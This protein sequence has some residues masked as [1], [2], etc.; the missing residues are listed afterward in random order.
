MTFIRTTALL[1]VP[2]LTW[3]VSQTSPS[4]DEWVEHSLASIES[5]QVGMT[6]AELE[7]IFSKEGGLSTRNH[8]TYVYRDCRYFKVDVVFEAEPGTKSESP[9]DKI[10]SISRP[11]LSRPTLD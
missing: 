7:Q 8:R 1:L 5:I 3:G 9:E 2:L 6:R 4:H 10:T 11:Y